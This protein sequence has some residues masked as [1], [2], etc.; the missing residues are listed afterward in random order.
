[1]F[2]FFSLTCIL[3]AHAHPYS[4]HHKRLPAFMTEIKKYH[5]AHH[6]KN[7]ELGFGVTSKVWDYVF[8]TVLPM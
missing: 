8:N 1:M 7:F 5:L 2:H 6:Y 3:H 4:M